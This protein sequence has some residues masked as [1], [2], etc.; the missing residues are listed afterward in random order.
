MEST[1]SQWWTSGHVQ[2]NYMVCQSARM[3]ASASIWYGGNPLNSPTSLI[4]IELILIFVMTR[5]IHF[6]LQPI[7]QSTVIAHVIAGIIIGPSFLTRDRQNIDKLF[8][9]GAQYLLKTI[10]SFGFMLHLFIYGVKIDISSLWKSIRGKAILIGLSGFFVSFGL[11]LATFSIVK[12]V[13]GLD[14]S[15]NTGVIALVVLNSMTFFIVTTSYCHEIKVSNSVVSGLACSSSFIIDAFGYIGTIIVLTIYR[16]GPPEPAGIRW[17]QTL[18]IF[19]Y[20]GILFFIF[21]PLILYIIR[22]T[23]E[24][25]PMKRSHFVAIFSVVLVVWFW[26]ECLGQ[27]LSIFLFGL[28]LP[29]GPPLGSILAQKLEVFTSGLLLPVFCTVSGLATNLHRL[30]G[31]TSPW[32]LELIFVVCRIGKFLGTLLSS[33]F[34]SIPLQDAIPLALLMCCQGIMEVIVVSYWMD[35]M[36]LNNQLFSLS[37]INIV[38]FTGFILPLIQSIYDPSRG[39]R[40]YNKRNVLGSNETNELQILVCIHEEENVPTIIG[41]LEASKCSKAGSTSIIALQLVQLIGRA[42]PIMGPLHQVKR[43]VAN[44]TCADHIANAFRYFERHGQGYVKVQHYVSVTSYSSMDNDICAL[45][46][47]KRSSLI[48][49][50]F[51]KQ[52]AIDGTVEASSMP[53]RELNRR[54]LNKAPCSVAILID[55][56]AMGGNL[57][58]LNNASSYH[59]V[60]LF[61]GGADDHEALAIARRMANNPSTS[62]AVIW[63]K[64]EGNRHDDSYEN[65]LDGEVIRDFQLKSKGNEKISLVENLVSDGIGTTKAVLSIKNADLIIVGRYHEPDCPA[66]LGITMWSD[67]PELGMLGDMLTT[68]SDFRFSVL[69]VQQQPQSDGSRHAG[70]EEVDPFF[71]HNS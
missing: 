49:V 58:V 22:L 70:R 52:W 31:S 4:W 27:R 59:V 67:Y 21:R 25:Q 53:M 16:V 11:G 30:K 63:L 23:P 66:T 29:D 64:P 55:R 14:S 24:G 40:A 5:L 60:M 43:T 71:E 26:G 17:G 45:A 69:V 41:M 39:Y 19:I 12:R 68:T 62:L 35:E 20:Y 61:I 1:G 6:C 38:L 51:H 36:I 32:T 13:G 37:M 46:H 47:D 42:M 10:S 56:G 34:V 28:S 54:V 15:Y 48:I 9:P 44:L 50:P 65:D 7:R 8:P 18:L 33:L 57:C 3:S 2:E